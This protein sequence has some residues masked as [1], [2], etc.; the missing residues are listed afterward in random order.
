MPTNLHRFT[1]SCLQH[2]H[3]LHSGVCGMW[4]QKFKFAKNKLEPLNFRLHDKWLPCLFTTLS[5]LTTYFLHIFGQIY[6]N[7]ALAT[8]FTRSSLQGRLILKKEQ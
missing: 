3:N 2:I 7:L 4:A 1:S 5:L 8:A 6:Q